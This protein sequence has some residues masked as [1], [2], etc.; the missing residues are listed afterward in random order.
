MVQAA[1]RPLNSE[2]NP[3][4][5]RGYVQVYTGNGKGKTTAA[6]GLAIRAIGAGLKVY[7]AQFMKNGS[8]SEFRC[9]QQLTDNI[10]IDSFLVAE[11]NRVCNRNNVRSLDDLPQSTDWQTRLKTILLSQEFDIVILEEANMAIMCGLMS[12]EDI[13]SVIAEKPLSVELVITGRYA[14]PDI[15]E[16]ADL[17][18]DMKEVK[19][20]YQ[21]GVNARIG[22]EQ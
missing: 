9:I 14:H 12:T 4:L 16:R 18:T 2:V 22:I 3:G 11:R 20:Y 15:I 5:E 17:V 13:L 8:S 6:I 7:I 1:G 10:K 21:D 19:H